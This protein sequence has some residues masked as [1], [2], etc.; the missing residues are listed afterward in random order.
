MPSKKIQGITIELNADCA[1]ILDGL[2]GI[3]KEL[4]K[5]TKSLKD[6]D[7]LLKFDPD[8][9]TLLGQKQEYLNKAI[10]ETTKQLEEEQRVLAELKG[11]DN[12]DKTVEQQ[13]AL[14]RAIEA[15]KAKLNQ[16]ETQLDQTSNELDDMGKETQ[17]AS[18]KTSMFGDVLKANLTSD[19]IIAGVKALANGIKEVAKAS[20]DVGMQFESSMSQVAATMGM[21]TDE[22]HNGSA[23]Y[24][25]LAEAAKKMGETTMFS[26]SEAADALN[27]LALAGYDADKA[28]E[29]L[30]KVLTLAASGGMELATAS[31]MVTDA[32]SALGMATEDVDKYIDEMA[33]TAQKSNTSVQQLGEATLVAAGAVSL[34]GQS[35]ETMN[36]A[37]GV[38]ANNG[39]KSAEGGTRLRNVLLSLSAPTD[40]ASAALD[41]LGVSIADS[42]GDMRDLQDIM[43]DL[44]ASLDGLGDAEKTATLKQIFNKTDIG[45]V[46]ALLKS[47]SGEFANLRSEIEN[48][49]GAAQA[50]ANT[51]MDNLEGKLTI[52]KS[53]LEGL[54][55]SV[56]EVFGS[57][58]SK[59]ID[60]ATKVVGKLQDSVKNGSMGVS[61]RKLDDALDKL[62]DKV[63]NWLEDALPDIIDG[64]ATIVEHADDIVAVIKGVVAGFV[65]LKTATL[66][67]EGVSSAMRIYATVTKNAEV[68]QKALNL[69]A[70]A[71]PYI[72]LATAIV[73]VGAALAGLIG[74]I[75]TVSEEYK[76]LADNTERL[77]KD[78]DALAESMA[79][80]KQDY[81]QDTSRI[82]YYKSLKEELAKLNAQESLDVGQKARV[83]E[84]V[85][86]LNGAFEDL[87]LKIDDETGKLSKDTAEWE[88]NVDAR[89]SAARVTKAQERIVEISNEIA[90]ADYKIWE[91]TQN[92]TTAQ[93]EWNRL[94]EEHN[95]LTHSTAENCE[96]LAFQLGQ[97]EG[98][99]TQQEK[100]IAANNAVIEENQEATKGA[101]EEIDNLT[102]YVEAN[103]EAE[104]SN[105]QATKEN[106]DA[107]KE[108]AESM[109]SIQQ[110]CEELGLDYD[111]LKQKSREALESQRSDFETLKEQAK[112]SVEDIAT[113]FEKQA[114]GIKQ[115]AKDVAEAEAIMQTDPS[116]S[117]LLQYYIDKGPAAASELEALVTAFK[118]GGEGLKQFQDAVAAFNETDTLLEG[119][120]DLG[121]ALETGY[122]E[123]VNTALEA[124]NEKLPEVTTAYQTNY[125][126]IETSADEHRTNM[127][128]TTT[129]TI[130]DMVTS[131][132]EKSPELQD[133]MTQMMLDTYKK[134]R[135]AVG[136]P[137]DEGAE[138][139]A[140]KFF[141]LGMLIDQGIADGITENAAL[142][143]NALQTALDDAAT[144]VDMSVLTS[145]INQALGEAMGGKKGGK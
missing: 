130:D 115:Y 42:N 98:K 35:L 122:T 60:S 138:G 125:A 32:M 7:K 66:A 37:L 132:N 143:A 81:N 108:N 68:A 94:Q 113:S 75:P 77:K 9:V 20:M 27:Y 49:S 107:N 13:K 133:A 142:I 23:E 14:E 61:L 112:A 145:K 134:A 85:D 24:E 52:L 131:I 44:A 91:A 100:I 86:Q 30:P 54:G 141:E 26:A 28:V 3:D 10:Q 74:D 96:D 90:D 31:D 102:A 136:L 48:S 58:F 6:V 88:K 111:E 16:Y 41:S 124:L 128:D 62:L 34:T 56:S 57:T 69:A 116:T 64:L 89:I 73:G 59:T 93:E 72:L 29:I 126:D 135:I 110:K 43:T 80:S 121:V 18:N 87:N 21:T 11:S 99:M 120:A 50:M 79:Q 119:M 127:N 63:I 45:A 4:S 92:V 140:E 144:N 117:G 33:K 40:K 118:D 47:T 76:E 78:T 114:E 8:N 123:A 15:T 55:I 65:T 19:A 1:G 84:I 12:A 53:S 83:K 51:M 70:S 2:K 139:R 97:I 137:E 103:T 105:T 129:G 82:D 17:D 38:L 67:V 71:N 22:I 36:T 104:E 25:K 39:I 109:D 95:N 5:T 101:R 106:T 46:N